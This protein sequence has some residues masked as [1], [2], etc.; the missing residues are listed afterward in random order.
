MI[1]G[2]G[3][4]VGGDEIGRKGGQATFLKSRTLRVFLHP[5]GLVETAALHGSSLFPSIVTESE[6]AKPRDAE[7]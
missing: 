5:Q 6:D 3:S 7:D 4:E 1:R 2:T